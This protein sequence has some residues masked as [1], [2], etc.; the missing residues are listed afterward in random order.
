MMSNPP[1]V[2]DEQV[3]GCVI[4]TATNTNPG[5]IEI[6]FRMA[7]GSRVLA[8]VRP[9]DFIRLIAHDKDDVNMLYREVRTPGED[10][11]SPWMREQLNRRRLQ[12][13]FTS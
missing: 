12:G 4:W 6:E 3:N 1:E 2:T 10:S 9:G 5:P 11:I 7:S 13:G 8:V